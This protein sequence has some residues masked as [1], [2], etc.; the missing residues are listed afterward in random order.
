MTS[1]D[2]LGFVISEGTI[3]NKLAHMQRD[4]IPNFV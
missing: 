2:L 1:E 3:A 4:T